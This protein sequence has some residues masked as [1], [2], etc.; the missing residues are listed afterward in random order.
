MKRLVSAVVLTAV[1]LS[2]TACSRTRAVN[3]LSETKTNIGQQMSC[4]YHR[5]NL[6]C[7][8]PL[9]TPERLDKLHVM[10]QVVYGIYAEEAH[11]SDI[12]SSGETGT[13]STRFATKPKE[14]SMWNCIKTG[15]PDP[16][17]QCKLV[18]EA[19]PR[20]IEAQESLINFNNTVVWPL[21]EKKL[22]TACGK[23][24][25]TKQDRISRTFIYPSSEKGVL[26]EVQFDTYLHPGNL[27]SLKSIDE[28]TGQFRNEGFIW[29]R[30]TDPG[31]TDAA[32][33][34]FLPCLR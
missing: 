25:R 8:S 15:N 12:E 30:H 9:I 18:R 7:G 33:Q 14:Y 28:K 17:V 2:L 6:Y 16:A 29:V 27:D 23:P 13:Y 22:L 1:L 31:Y 34:K 5:D 20:N 4:F 24:R 26:V 11:R 19:D 3:I 21:T 32:I 10:E